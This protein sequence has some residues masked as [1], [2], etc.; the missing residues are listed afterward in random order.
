MALLDDVRLSLRT[1][2]TA[3]DDEIQMWIDAA[4]AD[5]RRCGVRDDLLEEE[6]M[7]PMA[8]GAVV[9]YVKASYGYDNPE[10]DRFMAS[11]QSML[12]GLLNSKANE[13]LF[14]DEEDPDGDCPDEGDSDEGDTGDGTEGDG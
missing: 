13:Y 4:V 9:C 1:M 5:M 12:T 10:A 8:K 3:T 6:T 14:P 11:Y 2:T 7:C